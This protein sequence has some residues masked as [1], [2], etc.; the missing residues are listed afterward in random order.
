MGNYKVTVNQISKLDNYPIPKTEDVLAKIGGGQKFIKLDLSHAYQ[1]LLLVDESCK[2]ATMNTCKGLLRYTRLPYGISSNP[3]IF[4]WAIENFLT[5]IT[6]V[7]VRL[8][9]FLVSGKNDP[10][11]LRNLEEVLKR[12]SY[13]GLSMKENKNVFMAA[14]VV[15]Y[16][17]KVT[18]E[19]VMPV[20]AN[21]QAI[22]ETLRLE[23]TSQ[24]KSYYQTFLLRLLTVLAPLHKLLAKNNPGIGFLNKNRHFINPKSCWYPPHY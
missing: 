15:Y 3:G 12:L 16:G 10:E 13:A 4:Q 22:K 24:L 7:I 17:H 19:G 23:N 9:G 20:E 8:D 5:G 1:Q 11:H 18:T 14:E 6:C 21:I 2:Y